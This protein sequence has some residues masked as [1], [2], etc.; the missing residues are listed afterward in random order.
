MRVDGPA[1]MAQEP[2]YTRDNNKKQ[3]QDNGGHQYLL[4]DFFFLLAFITRLS[5]KCKI[6]WQLAQR[7]MHFSSAS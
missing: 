5:S 2:S 6:L 7:G 1:F 4:H 3:G